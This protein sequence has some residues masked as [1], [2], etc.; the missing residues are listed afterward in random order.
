MIEKKDIENIKNKIEIE[1]NE[2]KELVS[3]IQGYIKGLLKG[4]AEI[5]LLLDLL[6]KTEKNNNG[7]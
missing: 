7:Q 1:I 2:K 4:M 5:D 3:Q 6:S